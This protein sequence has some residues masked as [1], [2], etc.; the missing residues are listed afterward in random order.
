MGRDGFDGFRRDA[1]VLAR[2]LIGNDPR[3]YYPLMR[4]R[5]G[6]DYDGLPH[7]VDAGT[8][9]VIEGYPR[10]ANTFAIAAFRLAQRRRVQLAHHAHVPAQAREGLRRGLPVVV[11]VRRPDE[12][13]TSMA[14]RAGVSIETALR[15]YVRFH[16]AVTTY[17][18]EIVVAPFPIVT[19]DF[20][21]VIRAINRRHGTSYREFA[22]TPENVRAAMASVEARGRRDAARRGGRHE[23]EVG[24]PSAARDARKQEL[25][26]RYHDAPV[27]LRARAQ[28]LFLGLLDQPL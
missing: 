18:P 9:V 14:I 17:A 15:V 21:A 4:R 27:R 19:H 16:A 22:H 7:L 23:L 26:S 12:A 28:E 5:L 2:S 20:G 24:R 11:L 10:S 8:E 13:V 3:V 25:L 6:T 1:L